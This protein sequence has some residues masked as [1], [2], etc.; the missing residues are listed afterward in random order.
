M[1]RRQALVTQICEKLTQN[2]ANKGSDALAELLDCWYNYHFQS[3][4][5]GE[6]VTIIDRALELEL[7][8][9]EEAQELAR[10]GL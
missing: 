6:N 4:H 1:D 8:T 5:E 7:I 10:T 2:I 9:L 3:F